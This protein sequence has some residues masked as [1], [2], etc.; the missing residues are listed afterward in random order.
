MKACGAQPVR[1]LNR[2]KPRA[3]GGSETGGSCRGEPTQEESLSH[4]H[5]DSGLHF[6]VLRGRDW[7]VLGKAAAAEFCPLQLTKEL[8]RLLSGSSQ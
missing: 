5:T 6:K 7:R 4:V 3:G 1:D 8:Q 2:V